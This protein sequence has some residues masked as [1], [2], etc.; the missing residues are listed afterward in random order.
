M[1]DLTSPCS[2]IFDTSDVLMNPTLSQKYLNIHPHQH[3]CIRL[4]PKQWED[5]KELSLVTTFFYPFGKVNILGK[6]I[7]NLKDVIKQNFHHQMIPLKYENDLLTKERLLA[8][9][10]DL[11]SAKPSDKIITLKHTSKLTD[12]VTE[13]IFLHGCLTTHRKFIQYQYT[14]ND[15]TGLFHRYQILSQN[16]E[17]KI[18]V[19]TYTLRKLLKY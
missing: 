9:L 2:V 17:G 6:S 5:H 3:A 10:T 8:T 11:V 4:L 12:K 1:S 18:H 16:S 13:H 19:G 7:D 15:A 14:N